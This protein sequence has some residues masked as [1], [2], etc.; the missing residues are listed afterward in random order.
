MK[1]FV[2]LF[3]GVNVGGKNKLPMKDLAALMENMGL[4]N[5]ST[6]IQSGNVVFQADDSGDS[7]LATKIQDAILERFGFS[8]ELIIVDKATIE[9]AISENPFRAAESEPN[10]VHLMFLSKVPSDPDVET[11]ERI[12]GPNERFVLKRKVFYLHTPD[13]IG[14]SKLAARIE[15]SLG[16]SGTAR[17]WRTV[18]KLQEMIGALV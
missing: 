12:R 16:V 18:L 9:K 15:R 14:R 2:A 5:V 6:Y 3:R 8:P 1:T 7:G 10:R 4:Q 11:L 13:G 17:N